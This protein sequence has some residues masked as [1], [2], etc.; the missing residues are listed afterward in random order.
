MYFF[1]LVFINEKI[2]I[3]YICSFKIFLTFIMSKKKYV[4][5]KK[6][7][8]FVKRRLK[9]CSFKVMFSQKRFLSILNS[10]EK[11]FS[12]RKERFF[13]LIRE[14]ISILLFFVFEN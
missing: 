2:R 1:T 6:I 11:K 14:F 5:L 10:G 12:M 9:M 8:L 3:Y 13:F 7:R 4:K